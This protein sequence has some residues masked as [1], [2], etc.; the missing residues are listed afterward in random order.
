[1]V[2]RSGYEDCGLLPPLIQPHLSNRRSNLSLQ[3]PLILVFK[4]RF[5]QNLGCFKLVWIQ[6]KTFYTDGE[7][8]QLLPVVKRNRRA[9]R[10]TDLHTE[11]EKGLIS[12]QPPLKVQT[13]TDH[14][15]SGREP[16]SSMQAC[17]HGMT[18]RDIS[19]PGSLIYKRS[20]TRL[21]LQG[22]VPPLASFFFCILNILCSFS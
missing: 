3:Q 7:I 13:M 14:Q 11:A 6:L 10:S 9:D 2:Q 15:F 21:A 8:I 17:P 16:F 5:L 4:T 20:I 1:M 18:S 12:D 22:L 19:W